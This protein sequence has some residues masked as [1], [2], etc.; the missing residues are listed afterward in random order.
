MDCRNWPIW[1]NQQHRG[2]TSISY[3][4]A[5][6][7]RWIVNRPSW[8]TP[9]NSWMRCA[10]SSRRIRSFRPR[11]P[12]T[13]SVSRRA[14][15]SSAPTCSGATRLPS[16][17]SS[18]LELHTTGS[19]S[20]S[21]AT[22]LLPPTGHVGHHSPCCGSV[23]GRISCSLDSFRRSISAIR[24]I[25]TSWTCI[26]PRAIFWRT[27]T[28]SGWS[29]PPRPRPTRRGPISPLSIALPCT[30]S[31]RIPP[32]YRK[33]ARGSPKSTPRPGTSP[34]WPSAPSIPT[35]GSG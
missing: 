6:R 10:R 28:M 2:P 22:I 32:S 13:R 14:V 31:K 21:T 5:T 27:S 1:P 12:S 8:A 29:R 19:P 35:T 23:D 4:W 9:R 33:R 3:G 26:D 15:S 25:L 24:M 7:H 18:P 11:R 16:T 34:L 30:C 17:I 20:S